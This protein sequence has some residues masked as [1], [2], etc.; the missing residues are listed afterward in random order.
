MRQLALPLPTG[1]LLSRDHAPRGLPL[2]KWLPAIPHHLVLAVL[3][4]EPAAPPLHG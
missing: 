1:T 2:V 3:G 4:V